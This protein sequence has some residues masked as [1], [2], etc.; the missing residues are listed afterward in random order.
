LHHAFSRADIS[1]LAQ[2]IHP[3]ALGALALL[4]FLGARKS[5]DWAAVVLLIAAALFI[6][7]RR[8]P[9]YQ[10]ITSA[11]PWVSFDAGG[12]IFVPAATNRLFTCL[13]KFA[14]ENI[15]P[16]ERVLIAP[17]PIL[18]HESP[19]W[20]L[21]YYFSGTAERQETMIHELA[22]KNVNWAI[23]SDKPLDKREDLRFSATHELVW[24]YLM[25]N[26]EPVESACLAKSMKILH[27]KHPAG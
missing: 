27:R 20:D 1:H 23:I 8:T 21:A 11:T 15:A 6:V 25:E 26:F 18:G 17:Y 13:R 12:K 22:A 2:V 14:A 10:R 9:I 3:F 19:L 4:G 7:S 5:Y 16:R 24:Q